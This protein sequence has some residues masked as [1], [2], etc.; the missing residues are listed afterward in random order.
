MY[1]LT[2]LTLTKTADGQVNQADIVRRQWKIEQSAAF[3]K[4]YEGQA[5]GRQCDQSN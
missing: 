1:R 5:T 4:G 2:K 3:N